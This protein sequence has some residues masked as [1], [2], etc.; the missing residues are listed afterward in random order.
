MLTQLAEALW[1]AHH[2]HTFIGL[3]FGARMTIIKLPDGSLLLHSPI[4]ITD[5]LAADIDRLGAVRH[6]IAPNLFHHLFIGD[7][8]ARWPEATVYGPEGLAKKRPDLTIDRTLSPE[9]LP[10]GIVGVSLAGMAPLAET[11]LFH[12]P[13]ATLVSCDLVLNFTAPRGRWTKLYLSLNGINGTPGVSKLVATTAFKDHAAIR[14]GLDDILALP[15]DRL[16]VSHGDVLESGGHPVFQE[17][18]AWLK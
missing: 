10:E 4:P 11:V 6:L 2:P 16:I 13:S 15:F 8:A 7:A 17:S 18:F 5:G 14:K 12:P 3:N 9:V 1:V